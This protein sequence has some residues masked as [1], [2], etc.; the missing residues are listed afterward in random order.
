MYC[1]IFLRIKVFRAERKLDISNI[2]GTRFNEL[3]KIESSKHIISYSA[4]SESYSFK[5]FVW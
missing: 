3:L 4:Y 5:K 2:Q 1:V